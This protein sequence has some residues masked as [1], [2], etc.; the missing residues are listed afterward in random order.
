MVI[1]LAAASG[2]ACSAGPGGAAATPPAAPISLQAIASGATAIRLDW[3]SRDGRAAWYVIYRDGAWLWRVEGTS[4]T[5]TNGG[6]PHAST[7]RYRT[8]AVD[9]A[10]R[11]SEPS[12]ESCA[13]TDL[14]DDQLVDPSNPLAG[15]CA[16]AVDAGGH[17]HVAW[18]VPYAGTAWYATDRSGAWAVTPLGPSTTSPV[19]P[20]IAVDR[21]GHVH[22]AF[23]HDSVMYATDASGAGVVEPAAAGSFGGG[24]ALDPAGS[25]RVAFVG[26][27]SSMQVMVASR[28]AGAWA[29]AALGPA[30]CCVTTPSLAIDGAGKLHLTYADPNG[31]LRYGTDASGEFVSTYV[32]APTGAA[33]LAL[34]AAGDA[35]V[36]YYDGGLMYATDRG[37]SWQQV[38][39]V[40]G[41]SGG[42]FLGIAVDAGGHVHVSAAERTVLGKLHYLTDASGAWK[43]TEV[44]ADWPSRGNALA[45]DAAGGVH[46]CYASSEGLRV[47]SSR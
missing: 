26:E 46:L 34:D 30:S 16:I 33:A 35:H 7:H 8:T 1:V 6:L 20:G 47:A 5:F 37:G 32:S 21:D 10:G 11:E 41:S 15:P 9:A 13:T 2:A 22:V 44:P 29:S 25:P 28:E 43:L 3:Q 19:A 36:A 38:P 24:L 39:L 17:V 27:T 23:Q 42:Y 12:D 45:L 14:F 18:L 4:L 31:L 40:G